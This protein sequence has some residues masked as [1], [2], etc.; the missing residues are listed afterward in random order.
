MSQTIA[1]G[2]LRRRAPAV[3]RA[4]A[5]VAESRL[6]YDRR[7]RMNQRSGETA[8]YM[9]L[10]RRDPCAWC[11]RPSARVQDV[12]HI[13]PLLA[14]GQD[15]WTNMTASC[16]ACNRGRKAEAML[17]TLVRIRA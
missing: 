9:A 5:D 1:I 16:L 10:I 3:R 7:R 17:R 14:G 4:R 13:V 8:V 15:A 2:A 11:G 6:A 12:D